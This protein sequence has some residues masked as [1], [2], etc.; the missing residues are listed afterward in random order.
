MVSSAMLYS[1]TRFRRSSPSA[2]ANH[3]QSLRDIPGH[4][5]VGGIAYLPSTRLSSSS[6]RS[7]S[8]TTCLQPQSISQT[9]PET[10]SYAGDWLCAVHEQARYCLWTRQR[11]TLHERPTNHRRLQN[12]R[13]YQRHMMHLWDQGLVRGGWV[14]ASSSFGRVTSG[15]AV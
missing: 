6:I 2:T 12:A 13:I 7:S 9:N 8:T 14:L 11:D 3:T 10:S 4:Q 1:N 15:A 5:V